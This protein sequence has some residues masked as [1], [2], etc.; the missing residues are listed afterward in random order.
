MKIT[1]WN[2][3]N[4]AEDLIERSGNF[5]RAARRHLD[6]AAFATQAP[7]LCNPGPYGS[8]AFHAAKANHYLNAA[9]RLM[10]AASKAL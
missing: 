1:R 9:A 2:S 4:P 5:R 3:T 8:E 6:A 10:R 7:H